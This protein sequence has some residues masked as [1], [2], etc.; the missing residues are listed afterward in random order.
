MAEVVIRPAELGEGDEIGALTERAYREDGF[1]DDDYTAELLDGTSRVRDATVLVA[2]IEDQ[3][4]G[5]VT[6]AAPATAYA[7]ISHPDELEVRMLAVVD[8]ARGQGVADRLMDE[9][10]RTARQQGMTGVVLSTAHSMKAAHRLYERR[11]YRRRPE[12]DWFVDDLPLIVYRLDL[13][14]AHPDGVGSGGG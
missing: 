3:V 7:E 5:S 8:H 11:G 12:R 13:D 9:V 6:I 14:G 1:V 4:A 10:E 2:V